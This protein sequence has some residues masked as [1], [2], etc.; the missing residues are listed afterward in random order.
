MPRLIW[1]VPALAGVQRIY[2]FLAQKNDAAAKHALTAI[3]EG[4]KTLVTHPQV[5]RLAEDMDETFR[6]WPI[7]FGDSGY[8]VLYR[9]EGDFV[10]ILS[11]RHQK[12]VA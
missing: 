4:V 6:D 1:S 11:L 2:R 10:T 8:V 12:E 5:G 3:R 7:N 9:N